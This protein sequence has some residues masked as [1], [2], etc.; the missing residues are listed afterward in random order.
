MSEEIKTD[1]ASGHLGAMIGCL[2]LAVLMV[3]VMGLAVGL[4][5]AAM[6]LFGF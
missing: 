4:G 3:L 2:K 5:Y 1:G 6:W